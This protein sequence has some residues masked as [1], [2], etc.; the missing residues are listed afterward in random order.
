MI[1]TTINGIE[2]EFES[3]DEVVEFTDKVMGKVLIRDIKPIIYPKVTDNIEMIKPKMR[4][5]QVT[6][7]LSHKDAA[8]KAAA[9]WK[10]HKISL[11]NKY[12]KPLQRPSILNSISDNKILFDMMAHIIKN[13]GVMKRKLEGAILNV[14]KKS[15]W[16]E[17][18]T[19]ILRNSQSIASY[20]N[21][22]NK[23]LIDRIDDDAVLAYR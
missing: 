2:Y 23:F 22:E 5:I 19:D 6:E 15:E 1:K 18:L 10:E 4:K 9:L 7:K 8:K 16:E 12:V 20:F 14:N 17:L 21:V 3:V 11:F 13:K